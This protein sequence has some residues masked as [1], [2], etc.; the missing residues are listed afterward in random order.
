MLEKNKK[1]VIGMNIAR[2][3]GFAKVTG[4]LQYPS[5]VKDIPGMLYGAVLRSPYPCG[6]S[7]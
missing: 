2:S 6:N 1:S 5:D 4:T 3:D 7:G